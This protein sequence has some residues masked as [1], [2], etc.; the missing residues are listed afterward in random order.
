MACLLKLGSLP[1][2]ADPEHP[3]PA[4]IAATKAKLAQFQE[5]FDTH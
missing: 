4:E 3:T 2:A 1:E 5:I